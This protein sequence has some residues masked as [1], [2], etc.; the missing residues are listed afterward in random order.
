M[1]KVRIAVIAAVLAVSSIPAFAGPG[2]AGPGSMAAGSA[3]AFGGGPSKEMVELETKVQIL[4]DNV[5]KLQQ[6]NDERMGVLKD[7]VQQ[8][9]DSVNRMSVTIDALQKEVSAQSTAQGT[10]AE[11][12]S[13]Q[14]QSLN[15]SIDE[16]KARMNRLDKAVNEISSQQQTILPLIQNLPQPGGAQAAQAGQPAAPEQPAAQ[17]A[18][19]ANTMPGPEAI[20]PAGGRGRT[21]PAA[22]AAGADVPDDQ[23]KSAYSDYMAARY[24]VAAAEFADV[25]RSSPTSALAGDA[26]YYMAEIDYRNAKYSTAVKEYDK[27]I[28]QFPDS[29]KI[30][31][32]HLHKGQA[33]V[34]MQLKDAGIKEYRALIQRFPTSPEAAQ[35]RLKLAALS[36][37]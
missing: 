37:R 14:L 12:L 33:Y 9:S 8:N 3:A 23:F 27:V 11:T 32:A 26:Y 2:G 35:A 1:N 29:R 15:D 13:G 5:G 19:A 24:N 6:S 7:L 34:Q 18:M 28:E 25:V 4:L 31:A 17:P 10:K 22:A 36:P 21:A 16:I 30:P 20:P